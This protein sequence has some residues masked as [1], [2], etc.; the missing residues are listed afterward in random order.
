MAEECE[1]ELAEEDVFTGA[2]LDTDCDAPLYEEITKKELQYQ[3]DSDSP[4]PQYPSGE[5]QYL[6]C[7]IS[8]AGEHESINSH[9]PEP[10]CP[11][12]GTGRYSAVQV[13]AKNSN[14]ITGVGREVGGSSSKRPT[15]SL[16]IVF[17]VV[18]YC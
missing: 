13:A 18:V 12:G 17:S 16:A 1:L 5:P 7:P 4:E 6:N 2:S 14:S 10:Q 3:A 11:S 8:P 15:Y 9:H